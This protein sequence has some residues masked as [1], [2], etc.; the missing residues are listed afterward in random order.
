M[1]LPNLI[2]L[3]ATIPYVGPVLPYIPLAC[4]LAS[5]VDAVTPPPNEGS[6]W[7]PLRGFV[8]LLALNVGN[9]RNAVQAGAVTTRAAPETDDVAHAEDVAQRAAINGTVAK[10]GPAP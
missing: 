4:G 7:V 8:H 3:M 6:A 2:A 5:I 10:G 9:A 1:D